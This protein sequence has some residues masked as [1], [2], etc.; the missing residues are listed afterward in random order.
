MAMRRVTMVV[1]V[2]ACLVM[3]VVVRVTGCAMAP[4]L[5][6]LA[7]LFLLPAG[8][9]DVHLGGLDAAAGH[10]A[11][12]D[13]AVGKPEPGGQAL[14]PLDRCARGEE[15]AQHHVATDPGARVQDGETSI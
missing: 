2:R 15:G 12:L 3:V 7:G 6:R 8:Q 11:H 10:R 14:Q 9:Q 13:P 1:M 4:R 5:D